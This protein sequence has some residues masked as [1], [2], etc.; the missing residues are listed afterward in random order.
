MFGLGM[1]ELILICIV[2]LAVFGPGKLPEIGGAVGKSLANFK[3]AMKG[4][5]DKQV[6]IVQ[7]DSHNE[8]DHK[9]EVK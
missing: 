1:P 9:Q 8:K 2:G 4:E 6:T 5:P 7:A 3:T